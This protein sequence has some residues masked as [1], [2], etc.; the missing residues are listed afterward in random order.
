MNNNSSFENVD[1][2]LMREV[3][4]TPKIIESLIR[5]YNEI[6]RVTET[7]LSENMP[8]SILYVGCGSSYYAALK[9]VYPFLTELSTIKALAS[10]GSEALFLMENGGFK[11]SSRR[12]GLIVLFSRS[13]ETGEIVSI[14]EKA[15]KLHLKTMGFTCSEG[16]FLEKNV[17]YA[18]VFRDCYEKSTYMTKS[19]IALTLMGIISSLVILDRIGV[20]RGTNIKEELRE[21]F[22]AIESVVRNKDK[23]RSLAESTINRELFVI[24]APRDLYPIALEAALKFTEISYTYSYAM[25][26]LEFRHGP[27]ALLE[28]RDRVQIIVLSSPHDASFPYVTKLVNELSDQGFNILHFSSI[29]NADYKL[30]LKKNTHILSSAFI[31]PFYYFSIYRAL[32]LGFNPDY[33]RHISKVIRTI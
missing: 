4:E 15:R 10:P 23:I 20:Y 21:L 30:D 24:L 1:L 33:P 12:K 6:E 22:A 26:A 8:D 16:S 32:I 7:A 18:V 31:L 9:S 2:N 11:Q 25:H 17:D 3:E 13:G 14:V 28:K 27:I 19:F 5:K 29:D